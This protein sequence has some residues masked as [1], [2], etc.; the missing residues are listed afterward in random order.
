VHGG[1]E[2]GGGSHALD[3]GDVIAEVPE[4]G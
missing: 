1:G 2:I 4:I 3:R